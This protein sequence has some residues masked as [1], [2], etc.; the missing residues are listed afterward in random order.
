MPSTSTEDQLINITLITV[1]D[2]I[3][4]WGL[5][6]SRDGDQINKQP[7]TKSR[8]SG[9]ILPPLK[10]YFLHRLL[11]IVIYMPR[12]QNP[13]ERARN[14][15]IGWQLWHIAKLSQ[16]IYAIRSLLPF[17]TQSVADRLITPWDH[18][19]PFII[20]KKWRHETPVLELTLIEMTPCSLHGTAGCTVLH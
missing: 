13:K 16:L 12:V 7:T 18:R 5:L 19:K 1:F 9:Y 10:S 20:P 8:Q 11:T 3:R 17:L 15:K 2:V 6:G 4:R 14:P